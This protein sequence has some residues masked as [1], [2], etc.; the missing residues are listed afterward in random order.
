MARNLI[1]SILTFLRLTPSCQS[2]VKLSWPE[3]VLGFVMALSAGSVAAQV[4]WAQQAAGFTSNGAIEVKSLSGGIFTSTVNPNGAVAKANQSAVTQPPT[5]VI[6]ATSGSYSEIVPLGSSN[7][8][9]I[10]ACPTG[11]HSIWSLNGSGPYP[12]SYTN[13]AG[14]R[15]SFGPTTNNGSTYVSFFLDNM[16][17]GTGG[18]TGFI[19]PSMFA[20][21]GSRTLFNWAANLCSK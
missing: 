16:P 18:I 3:L 1:K 4:G 21:A 7:T 10:P 2:G 20:Q 11:Y 12:I 5:V 14:T 13:I 8:L 6:Q 19:A 17:T 15:F 9:V